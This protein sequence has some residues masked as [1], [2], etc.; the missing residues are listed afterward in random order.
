MDEA[1]DEVFLASTR[2][3]FE[4]TQR[5]NGVLIS[6]SNEISRVHSLRQSIAADF[7]CYS[8]RFSFELAAKLPLQIG[9]QLKQATASLE[10]QMNDCQSK[11][12]AH[13][14]QL[15]LQKQIVNEAVESLNLVVTA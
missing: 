15:Q 1:L 4:H 13:S 12:M 10:S 14:E 6:L 7:G 9:E 5:A 8:E 2:M 11:L 3:D